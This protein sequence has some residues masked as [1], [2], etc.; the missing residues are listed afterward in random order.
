MAG[1]EAFDQRQVVPVLL[2]RIGQLIEQMAAV[3]RRHAGPLWERRLRRRY[4]AVDIRFFRFRDLREQRIVERIE[5]VELRSIGGGN[6][7]AA[8]EEPRLVTGRTFN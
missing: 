4:R 7:I 1:I 6:E 8:D 3:G 2:D 5:D